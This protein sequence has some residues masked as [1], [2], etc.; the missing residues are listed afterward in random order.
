MK[1]IS[2][3]FLTSLVLLMFLN[4]LSIFETIVKSFS[5]MSTPIETSVF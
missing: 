3:F 1:L 4:D 2:A 5:P